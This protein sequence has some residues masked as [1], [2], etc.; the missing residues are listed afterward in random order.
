MRWKSWALSILVVILLT[1]CGFVSG[2]FGS[3][4][5]R[6][7]YPGMK[8]IAS[9][10]DLVALGANDSNAP[11][12]ARPMMYSRFS[13]DVYLGEKEV[14]H[15]EF[16]EMMGYVPAE[17][18]TDADDMPAR[19]ISWYE[20]LVYCNQKS[21]SLG[22]D[23]VYSW[24]SRVMDST[25]RV[26]NLIGLQARWGVV[27]IRLPTEAEWTLVA[28]KIPATILYRYAWFSDNAF[29][30]VQAVGTRKGQ[31]GF[32]D[33]QGNV[34]EW[35]QDGL[36]A[37][38]VGDTL[39]DY[40]GLY[41]GEMGN[42]S[43][44]VKGCS[45]QHPA[46]FL[47]LLLRQ[48]YYTLNGREHLAYLGFR[49][50]VGALN[51][52]FTSSTGASEPTLAAA[53]VADP[54][55][56]LR[57]INSVNY[58]LVFV[59]A[60]SGHLGML[61][62]NGQLMTYPDTGS[63]AHPMLSPDGKWIAY[64]TKHE[65]QSGDGEV[66]VRSA[67]TVTSA[68][69][70]VGSGGIPRWWVNPSTLDTMLVFVE[71]A[72]A[73]DLA[74]WAKTKTW[75]VTMSNGQVSSA[76]SKRISSGSYHSGISASGRYMASGFRK[77][78]LHDDSLQQVDTLFRSPLNG[79]SM[80]GSEQVCNVSLS[81]DS[82]PQVMFIDFGSTDSST[83]VGRP[84]AIHEYLFIMDAQGHVIHH[85]APPSGQVGWDEPEWA[86]SG[87]LA[88]ALGRNAS[89]SAKGIWVIN[90]DTQESL[91]IL[92][93]TELSFPSLWVD[94]FTPPEGYD[95][96]KAGWYQ[97][98][99]GNAYQDIFAQRMLAFWT[100]PEATFYFVGNSMVA[101]GFDPRAFTDPGYNMGIQAGDLYTQRELY[102]HYLL[103][104]GKK[105]SLRWIGI[106]INLDNLWADLGALSWTN[107][108]E[109]SLGR[110]YDSTNGY[111]RDSLPKGWREYMAKIPGPPIPLVVDSAGGL[112]ALPSRGWGA[113]TALPWP[114]QIDS[115]SVRIREALDI[116]YAMAD[117][118]AAN[119]IHYVFTIF[120]TNPGYLG[121]N[122]FSPTGLPDSLAAWII[123]KIRVK[124]ASN[125]SWG[126]FYDANNFGK[127]D[128]SN[129][130]ASDNLHLSEAGAWKL[131]R[132]IRDSLIDW[133]VA[134]Q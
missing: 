23:T 126:H 105:N 106:G 30:K 121:Q 52:H 46:S 116:W 84:Y 103:P 111:W 7:P 27:G 9:K 16:R 94:P 42:G 8:K 69:V 35:M 38:A 79:K 63:I 50:A 3:D 75:Q 48:D 128:Y 5:P 39:E 62:A 72:M 24:S 90:T 41:F 11:I 131:S 43:R 114:A 67:D 29:G 78:L 88:V 80:S 22:L 64:C 124:A 91:Q 113:A 57:F 37:Y 71:S 51:P 104:Q 15:K 47:N 134:T 28:Q 102:F 45:F 20:A 92:A 89:E 86:S 85:M 117:S 21:K 70:L 95:I 82:V 58:R 31:D 40:A 108:I 119:G 19:W 76:I 18:D 36:G 96:F 98:P 133:G 26:S 4:S 61:S 100:R 83:I 123:Q 115:N 59:D 68:P 122:V 120:P 25:G 101:N 99:Q 127:H 12:N 132:R 44:V 6:N 55:T 56:T 14:T 97:W 10:G 81:P 53:F 129:F 32:Y 33:I 34:M 93:G 49:V 73:N 13:G 74:E 109:H 112:F 2:L 77:L 118:A 87:H 110:L 60:Y 130:E 1:N 65:G 54:L 66:Y 17:A 125:G 107:N